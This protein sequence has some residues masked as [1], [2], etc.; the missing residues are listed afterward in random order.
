[1]DIDRWRRM[2]IDLRNGGL[3][4]ATSRKAVYETTARSRSLTD[5]ITRYARAL[6]TLP[7]N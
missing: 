6:L 5:S 4:S 7:A 3:I 1:V 2:M